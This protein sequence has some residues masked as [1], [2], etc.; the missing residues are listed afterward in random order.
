MVCFDDWDHGWEHMRRDE[1][2]HHVDAGML[3]TVLNVKNDHVRLPRKTLR[4]VLSNKPMSQVHPLFREEA[5]VRRTLAYDIKP[6]TV[7]HKAVALPLP[8]P[9]VTLK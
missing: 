6:G 9:K 7:L 5:I 3:T 1:I 8:P 2:I 4:I